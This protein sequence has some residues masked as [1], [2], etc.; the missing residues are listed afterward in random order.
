M[1]DPVALEAKVLTQESRMGYKVN[2]IFS[3]GFDIFGKCI[4]KYQEKKEEVRRTS[5]DQA[6]G[7]DDEDT[8][9]DAG[10]NIDFQ[11]LELF[12]P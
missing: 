10:V 12:P 6:V 7:T 11:S 5:I 4:E 1:K 2:N 3:G 8:S 9:N